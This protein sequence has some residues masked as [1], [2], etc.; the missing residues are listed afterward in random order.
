MIRVL[1]LTIVLVLSGCATT[2]PQPRNKENLGAI[3]KEYPQWYRAAKKTERKWGVPVNVQ[4]AIIYY[5]SAFKGDARPPFK[6]IFGIP[7]WEHIS[8]AYGYAQALDGTWNDYLS[9]CSPWFAKRNKFESATDFIGWYSS[10]AR[11][12]VGIPSNDPYNLYLAYHEGW[13]GYLRQ[14]Y[15]KKPWLMSYAKKVA[16]KSEVFQNQ[17]A[18]YEN[19]YSYCPM[20]SFIPAAPDPTPMQPTPEGLPEL[21]TPNYLA[22]EAKPQEPELNM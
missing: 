2:L 15:L 4:M 13:N 12:R 14:S 17:L 5:E 6:R 7:T 10:Q 16:I 19:P 11:N 18:Y 3:F 8:S 22:C 21:D 20:P 9:C 1:V